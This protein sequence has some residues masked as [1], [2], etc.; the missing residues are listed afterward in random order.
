MLKTRASDPETMTSCLRGVDDLRGVER[1][2]LDGS[3]GLHGTQRLFAVT[4]K[5][6]RWH[7][8]R[9]YIY[10]YV[11]VYGCVFEFNVYKPS[12]SGLDPIPEEN[13]AWDYYYRLYYDDDD[14]DDENENESYTYTPPRMADDY[15][16]TTEN[17]NENPALDIALDNDDDD[18]DDDTTPPPGTPGATSTPYQPGAASTPYHTG[19]EHEMT[20]LPQQ[21]SGVAQVPMPPWEALTHIY[22]DASATDLEAFYPPGSQRL[23]VK[24]AGAGKPSFA[25]YTTKIGD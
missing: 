2:A 7:G 24:M 14:D 1:D 8:H 11:C 21:Q 19:K 10:V 4:W 6:V 23:T 20:T 3:L 16:P 25:L 12:M 5:E 13:L 18:D 15:D 17:E 9:V 22:P